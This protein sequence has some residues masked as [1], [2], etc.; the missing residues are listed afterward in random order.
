MRSW[1]PFLVLGRDLEEA[2]DFSFFDED[3]AEPEVAVPRDVFAQ[4]DQARLEARD[5]R[6]GEQGRGVPQEA[7]AVEQGP[8]VGENQGSR[9]GRRQ[10]R[11]KL[12]ARLVENLFYESKA[13][14]QKPRVKS[15]GESSR[16]V[17][18]R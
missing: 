15:H 14:S 5:Q 2:A 9:G 11:Q 12:G 10:R 16:Q 4:V 3:E 13:T 17:S 8:V 1:V 18:P 7:E 6:G